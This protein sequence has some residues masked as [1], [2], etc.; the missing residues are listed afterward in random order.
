MPRASARGT[1]TFSSRFDL[2]QRHRLPSNVDHEGVG[3]ASVVQRCT[4]PG[5][6]IIRTR[7]LLLVPLVAAFFAFATPVAAQ[8]ETAATVR[9]SIV[10]KTG[11]EDVPAVGVE[12]AI[13]SAD[14][15]FSETVVTDDEGS[16]E[17]E[18]PSGGDYTATLDPATL[19]EGIALRN[20]DRAMLEFDI[21]DGA[22][23]ALLFPV[24]SAGEDGTAVSTASTGGG[25]KYVQLLVDGIK[26]GLIIGMCSIGLSLVFG[27]TG[28]V[29]FAHGETVTLGAVTAFLFNGWLDWTISI[30]LAALIATAVG[31]LAGG[32]FDAAVWAPLRRKGASLISM[33]VVSIG[34]SIFFRYVIL[35][36]LGGRANFYKDYALQRRRDFGLFSL[37][38]KDIFIIFFSLAVLIAVGLLLQRT[39]TGKAMRA[40]ADNRDL[41][42]SSGIDVQRV[43]RIVWIAGGALAALGGVLFGSTESIGWEM[44]FRLL[45]LMFAATTLGGLG[46]A[47]GALLGSLVVGIFIQYVTL[48][49]PTDMKN[50]GALLTLVLILLVR[51]QGILG[52]KERIG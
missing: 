39:R 47:Y 6:F 11:E 19:P 28:L 31:G 2:L 9:G 49:L 32:A 38:P 22:S 1:F 37:A 15:S 7:F 14:G 13:A 4:G 18:L 41:A 51:P 25:N 34:F 36:R 46:T 12:I 44:G 21:N 23:R 43:I 33:L 40:V 10:D 48:V 50:I 29:N 26:L 30:F 5:G 45:L 8:E 16:W 24:A 20:P 35:W 3:R 17:L 27:T 52:R 42:E